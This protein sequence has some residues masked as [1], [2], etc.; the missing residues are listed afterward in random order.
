MLRVDVLGPIRVEHDGRPVRLGPR[1]VELLAV[2]LVEAGSAVPADR[3]VEL[4]WGDPAPEAARATLR[5]HVSHLRRALAPATG[6]RQPPILVTTGLGAGSAYRLDLPPDAVDAD[7]FQRRCAE[8][9][10][11]LAADESDLIERAVALLTEALALWR[12]PAFAEV[13]DR[14]FTLAHVARLDSARR[15]A[16]RG[17][18]EA[19]SALGRWAEAIDGLTGL[20]VDDP[21]DETARRLLARA[22]YAD[23]RVDEAAEVCREGL[24]LLRERGLAAPELAELQR[25]ILH[26]RLPVGPAV[27]HQPK[28][29]RPSLLPPDPPHFVGRAD[30]LATARRLLDGSRRQPV[31]VLV[32]GPAGVGKTFFA[33]RLAH[34]VAAGFPDGQLYVDLRGFDPTG[35]AME[36]GEAA[37]VFLDALAVPPSRIPATVEAQTALYRSLLADRRVLVVLDN[38]DDAGRA[39]PLVPGVPGC[40]VIAVSRSQLPGLVAVDGARPVRLE[41]LDR[42]QARR[43][44]ARRL[45]AERLAGQDAAV[46]EIIDSCARLPLALAVAAARAAIHPEFPLGSLAAELRADRGGPDLDAFAHGDTGTDVRS[47][48][49]W[50]RRGLTEAADRLF[51]L[52]GLPAGPDLR[53]EALA[54]LAGRDV[55][56]V[57]SPLRELATAHLVTEHLPGRYARHDLLRAYADELGPP[58]G[59]AGRRAAWGR[60]LDHYLH[61]AL[62]ADRL[63]WPNRDPL[64]VPPP[65]PGVTVLGFADRQAALAWFTAEH[66]GLLAAIEQAVADGLDRPAWRLSW[67]MANFLPRRGH[68]HDWE[69][70]G[71]AGVTV[72]RRLGDPATVAE[73]HRLH[74][75]S[76]VELRRFDDARADY[77]Q[78]LSLYHD[79][80]DRVG[81]AFIYRCLG[82]LAEEQGELAEAL[83]HDE[84]ALTLF[85]QAGHDRGESYALNSVA[86]CLAQ[87]GDH[88]R[89]AA[90]G[91]RALDRLQ[92]AGDR[93]GEASVWDTLGH[94]YRNVDAHRAVD[95]YRQAIA[96]YRDL[97]DRMNEGFTLRR[98]GAALA[99]AGEAEAARQTWREALNIL[100]ANDHPDADRIAALL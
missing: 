40:A 30:E 68:R 41:L 91:R 80:G 15:T 90:Y 79:L 70:V 33:L 65:A 35:L 76:C 2:L 43:F 26:R 25:E 32:S 5:S 6:P 55:D 89:A 61:T 45:G 53:A 49:S 34:L 18:A 28:L 60:L 20:V 73:A 72:A 14:P 86:W 52:L 23:S 82:W 22:L 69:R 31:T 11:L 7:R 24:R 38:I 63:L 94:A 1:L 92:R 44:L 57:R 29:A 81:Q 21:Y 39:R 83:R 27:A 12:G 48:L 51:R 62:G 56:E 3:I 100:R 97:G 9:R 84:Q 98:L 4:L 75:S 95:C 67:A 54:S 50:S 71:R 93:M 99:A 88:E 42:G 78:A 16:R 59:S 13:A 8:A 37:R 74:G 36:P 10:R 19:L 47:V 17:H 46:D 66:A 85:R 87:L 77:R 96:R 64:P 58:D